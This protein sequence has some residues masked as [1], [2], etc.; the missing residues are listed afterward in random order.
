MVQHPFYRRW[1]DGG[2]SKV[3]LALY[4]AQYRHFEAYLPEFLARLAAALPPG[5]ARELVTANLADELG[6]PLAHVDLFDRFAAAVGAGPDAPSVAMTALLGTYE[7][8]LA[9]APAWALAGFAAYEAQSAEVAHLKADG[10]STHHGLDGHAVSFWHHHSRV[11]QRHGEWALAAVP[12]G[13]PAVAGAGRRAAQAWWAFL[14]EREGLA[15]A[16]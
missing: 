15:P 7:E 3:E 16:A 12:S 11:D 1:E 14:D 2:V 6:D 10:L 13:D 5:P 8:L 9:E 4:A